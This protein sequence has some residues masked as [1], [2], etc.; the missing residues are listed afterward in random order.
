MVLTDEGPG[1][2]IY[3]QDIRPALIRTIPPGAPRFRG[4]VINGNYVTGDAFVYTKSCFGKPFPYHVSGAIHD[5]I[6]DLRGPAAV[7]DPH[8][9][10]IVGLRGNS[11]NAHVVFAELAPQPRPPVAPPGPGPEPQPQ[12]DNSLELRASNEK[13]CQSEDAND[14]LAGCTA[15]IDA[16]GK[17]YKVTLADAYDGRCRSYNDQ[18]MFDRAVQDCK[19]AIARNSKNKY[20]YN[21]LGAG[22]T[23]QG[24]IKGALAA[25]STSIDLD[26]N[27]IY[28]RLARGRIYTDMGEKDKAKKNFDKVISV[29]QFNQQANDALGTLQ[30]DSPTLRDAR[31]FLDDAK[32]FVSALNQAPD[33]ISQ[34]ANAAVDLEVASKAFNDAAASRAKSRLADLL[35]PQPE[36]QDFMNGRQEDR[37]RTNKE[38]LVTAI[39]KSTI[40]HACADN[41]VKVT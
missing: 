25:Y 24:D 26:P 2:A 38:I 31:L 13:R 35:V 30:V 1:F 7:V 3:Y 21:H 20:A 11:D 16:Q 28:S 14:R 18:Q 15:I 23:G 32:L 19:T 33:S 34:I 36:F 10:T 6:I 37:N 9:C 17:D 5:G 39:N 22:L 4:R 40:Q 12:P 27:W 41:Y 8:S 29:D